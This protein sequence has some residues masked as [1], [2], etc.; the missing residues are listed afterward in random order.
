MPVFSASASVEA[1]DYDFS[2]VPG[3][4]KSLRSKGTVK[5]PTDAKIGAFLDG[6]KKMVTDAAKLGLTGVEINEDSTPEEM[7]AALDTVTGDDY[8]RLMEQVA[9]L[10][11]DLCGGS[12]NLKQLLTCPLRVRTAFYAWIMDEVVRPEGGKPD[13]N[14][15]LLSLPTAATG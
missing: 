5:E 8:V 6:L 2:A 4:P 11:A 1:L 10:Y 12:P 15:Q 14:G 9:G 7:L 13:G 3:W